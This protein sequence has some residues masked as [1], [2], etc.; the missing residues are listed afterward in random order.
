M[1]FTLL[2][3]ALAA[4]LA[5]GLLTAAQPAA[6]PDQL[7]VGQPG[8]PQISGETPPSVT[9]LVIRQPRTGVVEGTYRFDDFQLHFRARRLGEE[10]AD[11]RF[12]SDDGSF[13]LESRLLSRR[14]GWIRYGGVQISGRGQIDEYAQQMIAEILESPFGRELPRLSLELG[15]RLTHGQEAPVLAAFVQPW[16]ILFKLSGSLVADPQALRL[17]PG[18]SYRAPAAGRMLVL[19]DGEPMA[20]V[21][22]FNTVDAVGAAPPALAPKSTGICGASCRG[23]CGADCSSPSCMPGSGCDV[24]CATHPFCQWH[25]ACYDGCNGAFGCLSINDWACKRGCDAECP[26]EYDLTT[27][28]EWAVGLGPSTGV[29]TFNECDPCGGGGGGG[30]LPY[31]Q[32]V[33]ESGVTVTEMNLRDALAPG[34]VAGALQAGRVPAAGA[35][36]EQPGAAPRRWRQLGPD[37]VYSFDTCGGG[38][39][40]GG[41]GGICETVTVGPTGF[42]SFDCGGGSYCTYCECTG[43]NTSWSGE[44]C[45]SS[46]QELIDECW[47][48]CF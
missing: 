1:R 19:G 44:V 47:N 27:C 8:L 43:D 12:W 23:A 38:G 29:M 34:S 39:G 21:P 20:Y 3:L 15:C 31:L 40:G 4:I 11:V 36:P 46:N 24:T 17:S 48:S 6:N 22:Y 10:A 45:G 30:E 28:L 2:C 33:R 42:L 26:I 35:N 5:P 25:D 13:E 32:V 18:C 37:S 7:L 16:H 41:G 9:D 14:E